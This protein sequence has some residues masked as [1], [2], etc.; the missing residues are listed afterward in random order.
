M[1]DRKIV[2]GDEMIEAQLNEKSAILNISVGELIDRYLKR[3]L[4]TDDYYEPPK[5]TKEEL[6]EMGRKAV[7]KDKKRGIP[8]KKHNFD[9]IVGIMNKYED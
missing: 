8:P 1:S 6:Y 9:R 3:E 2:I 7:E 4:Y 5:Y